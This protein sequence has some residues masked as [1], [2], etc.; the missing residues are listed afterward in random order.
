MSHPKHDSSFSEFYEEVDEEFLAALQEIE[1]K[2]L[3]T[4]SLLPETQP[5]HSEQVIPSKR[6][7]SPQLD[8]EQSP[9]EIRISAGPTTDH[10]DDTYA[11]SRFGEFGDYMR[12]KRAK[13][14]IQN[15]QMKALNANGIVEE[16]GI[17]DLFKG[18]AFYVSPPFVS[19]RYDSQTRLCF[20]R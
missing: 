12:R 19:L 14:Q 6:I 20:C 3:A 10:G 17:R 18:L 16:G 5:R 15:V 11:A 8:E 1:S 4:T 2:E 9:S 7:L 13:L